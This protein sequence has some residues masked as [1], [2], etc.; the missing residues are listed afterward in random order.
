MK[1][2]ELQDEL[3]SRYNIAICDGANCPGGRGRTHSHAAGRRVCMWQRRNSVVSTFT[4]LH[5]I[6]HI[7]M[8]ESTMRRC[9]LEYFATVWALRT[10][11]EYRLKIPEKLIARYQ[12]CIMLEY[13]R[14][15]R[16]GRRLPPPESFTLP[17][18]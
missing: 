8:G 5:E 11:R 2:I 9:E 18:Y 17:R 4:L 3:I 7:E 12:S 10:A 1:Y 16:R 6:G 15:I 14:E 13:S